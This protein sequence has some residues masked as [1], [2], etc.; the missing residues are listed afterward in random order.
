MLST[1]EFLVAVILLLFL[2]GNSSAASDIS[3]A[4]QLAEQ[5][6]A[7]AQFNLGLMNGRAA[8]GGRE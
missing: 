2:V 5:G 8:G 6:D 1:K 3:A 7:Q 4:L